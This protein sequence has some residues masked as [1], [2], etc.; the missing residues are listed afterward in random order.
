MFESDF[1][2]FVTTTLPTL[3]GRLYPDEAETGS[4]INPVLPLAVYREQGL[5]D[6]VHTG[7]FDT[8]RHLMQLDLYDDDFDA[9]A[10]MS[11]AFRVAIH[12]Y[13]DE[14]FAAINILYSRN[15]KEN[16]VHRKILGLNVIHRRM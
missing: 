5:T 4:D 13:S 6:V 16:D 9:L 11:E 15:L 12:Q 1:Y 14:N 3:S 7:D 2:T 8:A 10:A